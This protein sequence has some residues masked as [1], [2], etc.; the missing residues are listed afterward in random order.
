MGD[1]LRRPP[2]KVREIWR[3]VR[4]MLLVPVIF[5]I[6]YNHHFKLNCR[7]CMDTFFR[8]VSID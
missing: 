4:A 3:P 8:E 1:S 7:M 2:K 6:L 5:A